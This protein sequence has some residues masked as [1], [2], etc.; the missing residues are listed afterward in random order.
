MGVSSPAAACRWERASASRSARAA[1]RTCR[2][3]GRAVADAV[4]IFF[5]NRSTWPAVARAGLLW[6]ISDAWSVDVGA[7]GRLNR[8]APNFTALAG[9]TLRW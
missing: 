4:S 8:A 2:F 6:Q 3:D 7:E 1:N 5:M 9:A